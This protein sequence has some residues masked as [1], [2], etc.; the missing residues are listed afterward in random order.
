LSWDNKNDED[1]D[2]YVDDYRDSCFFTLSCVMSFVIFNIYWTYWVNKITTELNVTRFV[3]VYYHLYGE[4]ENVRFYH[5]NESRMMNRK[6]KISMI[7][8]NNENGQNTISFWFS[9][10]YN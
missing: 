1:D 7:T 8:F 4:N 10:S 6:L 3:K 5:Q 9:C 2:D